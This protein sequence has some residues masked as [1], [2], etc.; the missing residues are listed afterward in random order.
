MLNPPVF[1]KTYA[2]QKFSREPLSPNTLNRTIKDT[3]CRE[4][5]NQRGNTGWPGFIPTTR[6][7]WHFWQLDTK[8]NTIT[9]LARSELPAPSSCGEHTQD[10]MGTTGQGILPA[11]S[12]LLGWE[13]MLWA[14]GSPAHSTPTGHLWHME[15]TLAFSW[16]TSCQGSSGARSRGC[17]SC[18]SQQQWP[19]ASWQSSWGHK[20][21][22][23]ACS[24]QTWAPATHSG[25]CQ[26][27]TNAP[28]IRPQAGTKPKSQF[29]WELL[30]LQ[31]KLNTL[32]QSM[33]GISLVGFVFRRHEPLLKYW[34]LF[35]SL[36]AAQYI[37]RIS[38]SCCLC[39][40][41]WGEKT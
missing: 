25:R 26:E 23:N 5:W 14:A 31:R 20:S 2:E 3:V 30:H 24:V 6:T 15:G 4:L 27:P 32:L 21:P 10:C 35:P 33:T 8:V 7:P 16:G 13:K 38:I 12:T 41:K 36:S 9:P 34:V 19:W 37:A 40:L 1:M 29:T 28:T 18:Q 22:S 39:N 17:A 11:W